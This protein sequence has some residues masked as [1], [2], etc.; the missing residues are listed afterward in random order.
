[1]LCIS[2]LETIYWEYLASSIENNITA[3]YISFYTGTTA[4]R[5]RLIEKIQNFV[6]EISHSLKASTSL[7]LIDKKV[8]NRN[9]TIGGIAP[10]IKGKI[11][12]NFDKYRINTPLGVGTIDLLAGKETVLL[13]KNASVLTAKVFFL[14]P[15]VQ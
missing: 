5:V 3:I 14:K 11:G 12:G 13:K 4:L 10:L 7:Y 15:Y 8:V 1:M 9:F 2:S 6:N